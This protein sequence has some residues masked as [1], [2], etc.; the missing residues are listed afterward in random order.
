MLHVIHVSGK[1][2]IVHGTNHGFS[3]ADYMQGM[4]EGLGMAE[5]MLPL[6]QREPLLKGLLEELTQGLD[7][8]FLKPED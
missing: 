3:W 4:M 1:R 2:V 8:S 5:F 7:A 6:H